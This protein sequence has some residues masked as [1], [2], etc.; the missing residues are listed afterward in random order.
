M[1]LPLAVAVWVKSFQSTNAPAPTRQRSMA[2]HCCLVSEFPKWKRAFDVIVALFL[3]VFLFPILTI[4]AALVAMDGGPIICRQ[5][6]A[7]MNAQP[8]GVLKFR[9]MR[10]DAEQKLQELLE[11]DK[12]AAANWATCQKLR[13]DPR[14]TRV[15]QFLRRSSLDEI[16]QLVN[17]LIGS[18]SIV[19]PRPIMESETKRYG[20]HIRHYY[21][22]RPGVT[23]LWQVNGR[24]DVS[25]RRRVAFDTIY[26]RKFGHIG[27]DIKVIAMTIPA[28]L[29][30][31]GAR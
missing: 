26:A 1:A 28:V 7:G 18:M 17:V 14:I 25:Y 13:D 16:P 11:R 21:H 15:G 9:T 20:H 6:R 10:H 19:G 4:V 12:D 30:G 24:S 5:Q 31:R 8:F 3:L 29:L 22:C 27:I 23:G 2:A